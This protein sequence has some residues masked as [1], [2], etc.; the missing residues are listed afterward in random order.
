MLM[1]GQ[2]V[3]IVD[4]L[5]RKHQIVHPRADLTHGVHQP[6]HLWRRA[7]VCRGGGLQF[8]GFGAFKGHIL[9]EKGPLGRF[10]VGQLND[11]LRLGHIVACVHGSVSPNQG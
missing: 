6:R 3:T 2:V 9:R 4:S 11:L 5:K 7:V 1:L 8:V 10:I